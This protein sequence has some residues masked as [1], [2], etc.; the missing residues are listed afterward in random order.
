MLNAYLE[1]NH[2]RQMQKNAARTL[3]GSTIQSDISGVLQD[4][5]DMETGQ[6]GYLL[7]GNPSYLQP[8]ADAKGKIGADLARLRE[9][10][11][12]RSPE[13]RSL[14]L[15][16]ETL[17]TSKQD[18]MQ[19][20]ISFREKG[21]RHRAFMLVDTDEGQQYMDKARGILAS[22]SSAESGS[23]ATSENA[24]DA[25]LKKLLTATVIANLCLVLLTAGLFALARFHGKSLEREA[26]HS[27]RRLA[28][29]DFQLGKLTFALSNK[30]R[31]ETS[32][33]EANASLLIGE[34]GGF[35]PRVG[36]E[37]AEQI[38]NSALEMERLQQELVGS[39]RPE[40][41]EK[42]A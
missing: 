25:A 10:L 14:E 8:Y 7:T 30:L 24:R 17:A 9:R 22:L 23:L 3:E 20:S 12:N 42:A 32:A 18:E 36:H 37:C 39:P 21:Y 1:I 35:L 34:Y 27:K 28:E 26:G 29:R 15:Q 16:L 38:K 2:L 4:F 41:G 6:R 11:A 31:S 13:E 19:R 33:I 5:T 40:P